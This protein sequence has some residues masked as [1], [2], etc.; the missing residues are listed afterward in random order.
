MRPRVSLHFVLGSICL[1]LVPN[2]ILPVS[3]QP[4]SSAWATPGERIEVLADNASTGNHRR[5]QLSVDRDDHVPTIKQNRF[6]IYFLSSM[7]HRR[8]EA[9]AGKRNP[10]RREADRGLKGDQSK[11]QRPPTQPRVVTRTHAR[12]HLYVGAAYAHSVVPISKSAR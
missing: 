4:Q 5:T 12:I 6:M 8:M 11:K 1:R 9:E 10:R 3:W 2:N 7:P